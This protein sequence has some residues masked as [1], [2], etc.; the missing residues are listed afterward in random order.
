MNWGVVRDVAWRIVAKAHNATIAPVN[1]A[2]AE[3]LPPENATIPA[4]SITAPRT[5]TT[6]T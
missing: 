2:S 3:A 5:E 6:A 4:T 1:V